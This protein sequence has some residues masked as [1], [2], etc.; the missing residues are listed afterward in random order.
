[1]LWKLGYPPAVAVVVH[2]KHEVTR[3]CVSPSITCGRH[4]GLVVNK[5]DSGLRGLGLGPDLV[6]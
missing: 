3:Y 6:P 5:L 2:V 4:G 1:M